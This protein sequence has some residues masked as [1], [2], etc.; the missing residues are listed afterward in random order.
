[1]PDDP[2]RP[3]DRGDLW[4]DMVEGGRLWAIL[5]DLQPA[6]LL[7]SLF[8]LDEGDL[9]AMVLERVYRDRFKLR[10]TNDDP[11]PGDPPRRAP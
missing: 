10:I 6:E 1:M 9:R 2:F 7:E 4:N 3:T 11:E 8:A 5:D